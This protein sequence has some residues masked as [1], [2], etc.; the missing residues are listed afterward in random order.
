MLIRKTT[1]AA[2]AVLLLAISPLRGQTYG[3]AYDRDRDYKEALLMLNDGRYSAAQQLFDKVHARSGVLGYDDVASDAEYFAAICA[4]ELHSRDAGARVAAFING[5]PGSPRIMA[6]RF[7]MGRHMYRQKRYPEAMAWFDRVARQD[8]TPAELQEYYFKKGYCAYSTGRHEV[9]N[10]MFYEIIDHPGGEYHEP[11]LYLYSHMA[12]EKKNHQT[13]LEG[14]EKLETSK[15]YGEL[16]PYYIAQIYFMQGRY[17]EVLRYIPAKLANVEPSRRDEMRRIVGDAHFRAGQYDSAAVYLEQYRGTA[18][19]LDRYDTYQLGYAYYQ[20]GDYAKAAKNL[21]TVTN[22]PDSLAQNAYYHLGDCYLRA[23]DKHNAHLA[24]GNAWRMP[25]DIEIQEDALFNYAKLTYELSFAPFNETIRNFEAYL[26]KFP[27]SNRRDEIYDYLVKV[28]LTSR[29]Y[30][31]ALASLGRVKESNRVLDNARQ[32]VT[33][34]YGVELFNNLQMSEAARMFEQSAA[35]KGDDAKMRAMATYWLAEAQNRMGQTAAALKNYN[36]FITTP[37][38]YATDEYRLTNY[39][40]GYIHFKN[41]E[42]SK[43][44]HWLR[45]FAEKPVADRRFAEDAWLRVG[46]SEFAQRKFDKAIE[47]YDQAIAAGD[48]ASEYARYQKGVALGLVD[49]QQEKIDALA[50]FAAQPGSIYA[51]IAAYETAKAH[52]RLNDRA[53]AIETYQYLANNFPLSM[54]NTKAQ[55]QSGLLAFNMGD[56]ATAIQYLERVIAKAPASAEATEALNTLKNVYLAMDNVAAYVDYA[57]TIDRGVTSAEEDSLTFRAAENIYAQGDYG[58]AANALGDYAQR[59]PQGQFVANALFYKGLAS[60]KTQDSA[61]AAAALDAVGQLP[62]NLYS[63]LAA[64]QLADIHSR[65]G[66]HADAYDAYTRLLAI[67]DTRETLAEATIGQ[68]RSAARAGMH[69]QAIE[70][71]GKTLELQGAGQEIQ[72]EALFARAKANHA[73]GDLEPALAD[74]TKLAANTRNPQGAESRYRVAQIHREQG[75]AQQAEEEL[76]AYITQS[77]PHVYWLGSSFI[78]LSG[79]YR[80]QGDTFQAKAY[81][82]NLIDNYP[83]DDDGIKQAASDSLRLIT[84]AEDNQFAPASRAAGAGNGTDIGSGNDID[85]GDQPA[86]PEA[87]PD[88]L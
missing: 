29:N 43:A 75:H 73:Q 61:Q 13:A 19:G 69:P 48:G 3:D 70:A 39:N 38:A 76:L 20:T 45:L 17:E 15:R 11:A 41:K 58:R 85:T 37:G 53:K 65:Q 25:F 88:G 86:A 46:D 9:A 64:Q 49:R 51:D 78:L 55:L 26:E 36:R 54:L 56:N 32:R 23:G 5:N 72:N 21:S 63:A 34:F 1:L 50:Y 60:L 2:C 67:A 35:T 74:Y 57:K 47:A 28:Y 30:K 68:M 62:R 33:F 7:Q 42:Y 22:T 4:I 80:Q 84:A 18:A 52:T 40:I 12:Y 14:F 82:Q 71:A 16:V 6:A 81:L 79:I 24:F 59:F 83:A 87:R 66:R 27:K 8:L 10:N 44:A 77:T 31:E